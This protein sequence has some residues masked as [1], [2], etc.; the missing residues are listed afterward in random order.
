MTTLQNLHQSS[1]C[2]CESY[3]N[4]NKFLGNCLLASCLFLWKFS[5]GSVYSAFT[6]VHDAD[7]GSRYKTIEAKTWFVVKTC[8]DNPVA[9]PVPPLRNADG[10]LVQRPESEEGYRTVKE[11]R[12]RIHPKLFDRPYR[13]NIVDYYGLFWTRIS[14]NI[15]VC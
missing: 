10:S 6:V 3:G 15:N 2:C 4:C 1:S 8:G 14:Q 12:T 9:V 11:Q 13:P 5:V 7:D